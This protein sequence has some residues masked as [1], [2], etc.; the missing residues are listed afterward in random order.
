M[1][2]IKMRVFP[3]T[4]NSEKRRISRLLIFTD[5]NTSRSAFF[6]QIEQRGEGRGLIPQA[7]RAGDGRITT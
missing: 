6:P 3:V 1:K 2:L 4:T 7:R 5:Y